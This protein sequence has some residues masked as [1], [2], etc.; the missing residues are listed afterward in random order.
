MKKILK[1]EPYICARCGYCNTVCPTYGLNKDRWESVSPRGKLSLIRQGILKNMSRDSADAKKF[2]GKL[3]DCLLC[4]ACEAACQTKIPLLE[5]W[6]LS[7]ELAG[8]HTPE[9]AVNANR[10]INECHDPMGLGGQERAFG[11]TRLKKLAHPVVKEQAE[12]AYFVG[13]TAAL[14]PMASS[15][16]NSFV[17]IL[18]HL[19]IE[20]S[21]LGTD[22][23]CC[24]FPQIL[25]GRASEAEKQIRHNVERIRMLG[26]KTIV[27]TCPGC[28][29]V[30]KEEYKE[31]AG[32]L[33]NFE[34][35]HSTEFISRLIK[36]N[37]IRFSES[38]TRVVT[39]HDP[40][41]LGRKSKLFDPPRSI[42]R[43]IPGL[44]FVELPNNKNDCVCCGSGAMLSFLKPELSAAV[45]SAKIA[46]IKT[47]EAE[48]VL[49]ACQSC[50][51][52]IKQ[53]AN[54]TQEQF[55]V[56]DLMELVLETMEKKNA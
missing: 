29:R 51:M 28:F 6:K 52:K 23:W 19:N 15:I 7:R 20:F 32:G 26:A 2:T 33:V 22:E 30:F 46:E 47:T 16:A 17:T 5:L 21:I 27:T 34:V 25:V 37:R 39:Y 48:I 42:I 14:L 44:R 13:C 35:V 1:T 55:K 3:F 11:T 9:A 54:I 50:K 38:G 45:S 49:S 12:I 53:T 36:E 8:A 18:R 31:I 41:D 10:S 4:G 40:C 43:A 56:M 24:G